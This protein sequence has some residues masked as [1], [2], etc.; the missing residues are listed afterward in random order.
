[1][2]T[3]HSL[4]ALSISLVMMEV[5]LIMEMNFNLCFQ[6]SSVTKLALLAIKEQ[7]AA[8]PTVCLAEGPGH[9]IRHQ[10]SLGLLTRCRSNPL[11]TPVQKLT[12]T[13]SAPLLAGNRVMVRE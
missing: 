13:F 2:G 3:H 1:M 9:A 4:P 7:V 10:A 8:F 5:V 6:F 11:T 12:L